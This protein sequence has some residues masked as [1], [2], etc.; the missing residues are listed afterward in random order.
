MGIEGLTAL[1]SWKA[2]SNQYGA[3]LGYSVGTAGDVNGDGYD[4]VI[5]GAPV[6]TTVRPTRA[7]RSCISVRRPD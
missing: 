3:L 5:V 6:T 1:P 2:Q 7:G 4:D